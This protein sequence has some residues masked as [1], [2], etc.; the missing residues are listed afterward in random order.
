MPEFDKVIQKLERLEK[1]LK[2]DMPRIVGQESVNFFAEN[3]EKQGF[4]DNSLT[5]WKKPKRT[6][7]IALGID[8]KP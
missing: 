1:Y 2:R 4:T 6:T 5:K 8:F 3:F 7:R